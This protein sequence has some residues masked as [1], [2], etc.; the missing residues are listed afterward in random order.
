MMFAQD[1]IAQHSGH[2]PLLISF[3]IGEEALRQRVS[4]DDWLNDLTQL[5]V[6]GFYLVI[7]RNSESYRQHYEPDVLASLLRVC[8]SLAEVNDYRVYMGYTDMATLLFH[9]VGVTGTSAGWFTGLRQFTLRRFQPTTGGRR[10]RPRYSSRALLNSIYVSELD[11]I[12]NGGQIRDVLSST[13]FDVRFNTNMNPED[14]PWPDDDA[15]RHHWHVLNDISQ[16]PVG[17][18][19]GSRLDAARD[20]IALARATYAQVGNLVPFATETGSSHLDQWLDGLN[21][22]RSECSV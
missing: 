7:K 9:A 5:G 2:K 11:G 1:T 19:I 8:Y 22:F 14:V 15:A 21:R 10:P 17:S 20:V 6:D 4:V 3:V 13:P 12:Y 18:T 16:S